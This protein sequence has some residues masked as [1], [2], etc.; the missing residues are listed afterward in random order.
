MF[1]SFTLVI[2]TASLAGAIYVAAVGAR[3]HDLYLQPGRDQP[4]DVQV[5]ARL[6]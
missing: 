2:V 5:L 3:A 4:A 1:R 6:P